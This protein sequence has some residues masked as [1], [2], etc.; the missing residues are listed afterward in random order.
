VKAYLVRSPEESATDERPP[1]LPL[2]RAR[3]SGPNAGS[4]RRRRSGLAS[5]KS[6]VIGS[7]AVII[8]IAS[9]MPSFVAIAPASNAPTGIAP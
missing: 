4:S 2:E 9:R 7:K 6:D 1:V 3:P 5:K 8:H